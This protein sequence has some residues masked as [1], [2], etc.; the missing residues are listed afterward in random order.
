MWACYVALNEPLLDGITGLFFGILVVADLP[1]SIV[2]FS[3]IWDGS[4][5]AQIAV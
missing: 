4:R 1:F 5:H 2:A 3:L